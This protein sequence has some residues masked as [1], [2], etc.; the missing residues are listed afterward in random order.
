MPTSGALSPPAESGRVSTRRLTSHGSPV[1]H[2]REEDPG[3]RLAASGDRR[4]PSP[5]APALPR[6]GAGLH[7]RSAGQAAA[8]RGR[9]GAPTEHVGG[10]VRAYAA[11]LVSSWME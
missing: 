2:P 4:A 8:L 1:N 6:A 9:P 5:T 3:R 10:R 11:S 7:T